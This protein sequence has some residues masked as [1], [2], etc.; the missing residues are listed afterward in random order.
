MVQK[1]LKKT[2]ACA[3]F[4]CGFAPITAF[5]TMA[6]TPSRPC[7][8]VCGDVSCCTQNDYSGNSQP[9][10]FQRVQKSQPNEVGDWYVAANF[11][12]N[13]WSW[14]NDYRSDY[15]GSDL[16]FSKDTYSFESVTGFSFAFGKK[17]ESGLRGDIEFGMSSTFT[18]ADDVAQFSMNIMHLTAN[19]YHDFESGIYLGAGIGVA[20][21][22][23]KIEGLLFGGNSGENS[24][25]SPKVGAALGYAK[26]VADNTFIDVRYRLSVMKGIDLSQPFMWDQYTGEYEQHI[27]Q[28][29]AGLILENSVSVGLRYSF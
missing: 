11:M 26:Q 22:T 12:M 17:F 16:L 7:G 4:L 15:T 19:I 25:I 10:N 5:A 14:E 21:P 27:L 6:Y 9:Y 29:E 18:D 28:I 23:V 3:M 24:A 20:K 13:L 8:C 1:M 2:I